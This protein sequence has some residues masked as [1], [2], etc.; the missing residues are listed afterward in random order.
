MY[1][2][3]ETDTRKVCDPAGGTFYTWAGVPTCR[4][5][6]RA[7]IGRCLGHVYSTTRVVRA[8]VYTRYV[9]ALAH[10]SSER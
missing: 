6:A 5:R 10:V 2:S 7:P 9:C 4:E 1:F 3:I 8:V